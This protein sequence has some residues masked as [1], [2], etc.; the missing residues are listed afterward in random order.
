MFEGDLDLQPVILTESAQGLHQQHEVTITPCSGV[1][2]A[3]SI[4]TQRFCPQTKT[5]S[6][7]L[8]AASVSPHR[9]GA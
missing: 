3:N 8:A 7:A 9:S 2:S 6:L 5:H 4:A 1:L